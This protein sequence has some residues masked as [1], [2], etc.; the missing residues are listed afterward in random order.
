MRLT[1]HPPTPRVVFISIKVGTCLPRE[2][3]WCALCDLAASN[4]QSAETAS[5][6]DYPL[7]A[8]VGSSSTI[9]ACWRRPDGAMRPS[10]PQREKVELARVWP[11]DGA[12]WISAG[13]MYAGP[14]TRGEWAE[15]IHP[16]VPT[17]RY[18][19]L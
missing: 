2:A 17:A 7:G 16:I 11:Y 5:L 6:G 10:A 18:K 9:R 1:C 8:W 13:S 15:E 14:N 12:H 3:S 4:D 19:M